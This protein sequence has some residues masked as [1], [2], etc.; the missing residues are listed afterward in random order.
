MQI[1]LLR[2][3]VQQLIVSE[4]SEHYPGS[5]ALPDEIIEASGL[6]LFE[7]VHVNNLTNGNRIITYVVRSKKDGF[8]TLNGAASKLFNRGDKIHVL[9]YGY[10]DEAEAAGFEPRIIYA[11][12]ANRLIEAKTYAF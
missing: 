3:K 12:E 8:V 5:I 6:R 11:D 9:S 7:L 1:Q 10:F 2:T 4:S